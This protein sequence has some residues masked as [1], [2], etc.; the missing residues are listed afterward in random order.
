MGFDGDADARES[1]D[2]DARHETESVRKRG[3]SRTRVNYMADQYKDGQVPRLMMRI[4]L[5]TS[6]LGGI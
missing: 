3:S 5:N 2:D 6:F 4:H 1:V